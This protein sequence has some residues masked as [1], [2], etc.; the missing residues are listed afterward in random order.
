MKIEDYDP[1]AVCAFFNDCD[2][3]CC[4]SSGP[5]Q[6]HIA[7]TGDASQMAIT[8]VSSDN[9]D[10][11]VQFGLSKTKLTNSVQSDSHTFTYGGWRGWVHDAVLN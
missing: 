1:H 10:S 9:A 5:E 8:W 6:I 4:R 7:L 11:T 2:S 3:P